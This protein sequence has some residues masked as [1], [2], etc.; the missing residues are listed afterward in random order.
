M[1][2]NDGQKFDHIDRADRY[3]VSM[4]YT[5]IADVMARRGAKMTRSRVHQICRDA[6]RKIAD[7]IRRDFPELATMFDVEA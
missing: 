1:K 2:R 7:A 5:E 6:E 3:G 4:T